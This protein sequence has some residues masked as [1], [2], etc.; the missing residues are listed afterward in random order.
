MGNRYIIDWCERCKKNTSHQLIIKDDEIITICIYC[1]RKNMK[2]IY[3]GIR[4][5]RSKSKRIKTGRRE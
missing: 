4:K 3:R 2:K 1:D 5:Q